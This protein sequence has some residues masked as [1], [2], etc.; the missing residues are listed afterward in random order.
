MGAVYKAYHEN[1]PDTDLA[2]KVLPRNGKTDARIVSTMEN[3][4]KIARAISGHICM[5]NTLDAGVD[6]VLLV[7]LPPE[8]CDD[9]AP[10][11]KARGVDLI[12]LI[13]P[14]T[15]DARISRI[16]GAASG[17]LY[18][19]SLKGVT[20]SASLN[21]EEVARR[22]ETIRNLAQLPIGVGFGIKD[23]QS[24]RAVSQVSDGVVVGSALVNQSA[25][26]VD[27]PD[28]IAPAVAAIL[29]DMRAAMDKQ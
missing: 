8:E 27:T 5:V 28:R 23:A 10:L 9:V 21:V 6:G 3:E 1:D 24:A 2:V 14:T 20:G 17:Y 15:T 11:F 25:E 4:S 16:A 7:D 29:A 26:N 22:V 19:V 12:F 18:Y 13:A